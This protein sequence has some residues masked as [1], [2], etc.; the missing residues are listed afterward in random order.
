[1]PNTFKVMIYR[2]LNILSLFA[3]V[4]FL[5]ACA[6]VEEREQLLSAAG[7][8]MKFADTPAKL[9]HLKLQAQHKIIPY[10]KEG[11]NYFVYAD[12]SSCQ[13]MYVGD[14]KAYQQFNILAVEEDIANRQR[15]TAEM[16]REWELEGGRWGEPWGNGPWNG[17]G[18]NF[19]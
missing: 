17:Y 9:D 4:G 3:F 11:K 19:Y 13:C 14:D 15:M 1:M 5:C 10:T 18:V 7:F 6:E 8:T 12:L 16:N 2:V